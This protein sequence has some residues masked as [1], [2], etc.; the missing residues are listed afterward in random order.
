M[1]FIYKKN[2]TGPRKKPWRKPGLSASYFGAPY[3]LCAHARLVLNH[4][5]FVTAV[6]V[7]FNCHLTVFA[8][9]Y[10]PESVGFH[11]LSN[12][13]VSSRLLEFWDLFSISMTFLALMFD[14]G[15]YSACCA[16]DY[17][18]SSFRTAFVCSSFLVLIRLLVCPLYDSWQSWHEISE[19]CTEFSVL[20]IRYILCLRRS[21]LISTVVSLR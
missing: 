7:T 4:F 9:I 14:I 20:N 6:A 5:L 12:I 1:S 15:Y 2:R 13:W 18:F 19:S 17:I 8:V 16:R 21:L 11:D 10:L 3:I